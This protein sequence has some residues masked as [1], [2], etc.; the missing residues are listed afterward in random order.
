M[1][2]IFRTLEFLGLSVWLGSDIFLSFCRGAGSISFCRHSIGIRPGAV[3][4]F[5]LDQDAFDRDRVRRFWFCWCG[6]LR[7]K[8][9][10]N[11]AA[12]GGVVRGA[13]DRADYGFRK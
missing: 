1:S 12:P 3:V 4:G 13:D 9:V 5:A 7:T 2:N 8:S 10:V 6:L 11:L